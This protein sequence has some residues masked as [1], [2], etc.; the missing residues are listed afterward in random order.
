[1]FLARAPSSSKVMWEKA[2][3]SVIWVIICLF[4]RKI[5]FVRFFK[6]ILP[7]YF[8][9]SKKLQKTFKKLKNV[10]INKNP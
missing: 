7:F 6:R 9:D 10:K 5:L 4:L 2:V 8:F 3:F 1:M